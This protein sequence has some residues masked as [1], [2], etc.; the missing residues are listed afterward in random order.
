MAGTR[1]SST[2]LRDLEANLEKEK[3]E[4]KRASIKH[5]AA[6]EALDEASEESKKAH[7]AAEKELRE[8]EEAHALA[9]KEKAEHEEALRLEKEAE[10]IAERERAEAEEARKIADKE[11]AEAQ[12]AKEA[13]DA[14]ELV[15]H[16]ARADEAQARGNKD[17]HAKAKDDLKT[18]QDAWLEAK[19]VYAKEAG[20]ADA[21]AA[22]FAKE[23][24]EADE[25]E[26]REE[27][28]E[29]IR[30][31]EEKEAEEAELARQKEQ[32]EADDAA[33]AAAEAARVKEAAILAEAEAAAI[34]EKEA[35]DVEEAQGK[36][37]SKKVQ[38]G[39]TEEE[40]DAAWAKTMPEEG[41]AGKGKR[42]SMLVAKDATKTPPQKGWFLA[43]KKPRS[44]MGMG[45]TKKR[46]I[47]IDNG[48]IIY[49]ELGKGGGDQT[50]GAQKGKI[51]GGVKGCRIETKAENSLLKDHECNILTPT[52]EQ[53]LNLIFE[54]KDKDGNPSQDLSEF[55]KCL[56][57]HIDYYKEVPIDSK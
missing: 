35:K 43:K 16:K 29:K 44:N 19:K 7:E 32:Q 22:A 42:K 14:A 15:L 4:L 55:I 56:T 47:T 26:R 9:E 30:I 3:E 12:A 1:V 45:T 39:V 46:V 20:E 10:V 11:L 34:K 54:A 2:P 57:A 49:Y 25:A 41:K 31:K 6:V 28:L 51:A 18:A 48:E 13:M 50:L 24:E 5:A 38:L 23:L 52:D 37:D 21:A 27:E 8:A 53:G 17:K 36:V 40:D 33:A